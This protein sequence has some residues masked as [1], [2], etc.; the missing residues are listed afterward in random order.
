LLASFP[1]PGQQTLAYGYLI[2]CVSV[3]ILLLIF[4]RSIHKGN[5]LELSEK[6]TGEIE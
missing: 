5:E 1:N 3:I 4:R 6:G 2:L